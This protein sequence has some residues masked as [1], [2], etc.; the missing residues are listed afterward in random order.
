[1]LLA[2][3]RA[4][5][6]RQARRA[7][8]A[9]GSGTDCQ[10]SER[11]ARRRQGVTRQA[12]GKTAGTYVVRLLTGSRF[13]D[14]ETPEGGTR[15]SSHRAAGLPARPLTVAARVTLSAS[16][17]VNTSGGRIFRTFPSLPARPIRIPS[18]RSRLTILSAEDELSSS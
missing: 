10:W 13:A 8:R 12:R 3:W 11:R 7:G 15:S 5:R 16:S 2:T 9:P 1:S 4:R 6:A 17:A 14:L 18:S